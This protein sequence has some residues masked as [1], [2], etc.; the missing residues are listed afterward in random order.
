MLK[1]WDVRADDWQVGASIQHEISPRVSAQVGYVRRWF[2]N[3]EITD[4]LLVQSV[5]LRS[6]QHHR[7]DRFAA[8]RRRRLRDR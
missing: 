2:G 8:A 5:G 4:N 6:L 3:F 1:G 7:A